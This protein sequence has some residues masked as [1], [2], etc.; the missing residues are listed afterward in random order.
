MLASTLGTGDPPS[1]Q[2][3]ANK[4]SPHAQCRIG[5][6]YW[7]ETTVAAPSYSHSRAP[8]SA[9]GFSN[10]S[11]S[12]QSHRFYTVSTLATETLQVRMRYCS[13]E[14]HLIRVC[15]VDRPDRSH[16]WKGMNASAEFLP[17]YRDTNTRPAH[18]LT[19]TGYLVLLMRRTMLPFTSLIDTHWF[20]PGFIDCSS[21][22]DRQSAAPPSAGRLSCPKYAV[23]DNL[24]LPSQEQ[25]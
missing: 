18:I 19:E 23:H 13:C 6:A 2:Q 15:S 10:I 25:R 11:E 17:S 14:R 9:A 12:S 5:E 3:Y 8:R 22:C 1:W 16:V 7:R 21:P 20:P 24:P 4:T